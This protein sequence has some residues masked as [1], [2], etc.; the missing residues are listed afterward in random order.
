MSNTQIETFTFQSHSLRI[1]SDEKGAPWFIAKDIF[2][3]LGY[4]NSRDMIN[5]LCRVSG[6]SKRYIPELSNTYQLIDEGNLYRLIIK[7]GKPEA[8]A[9]EAWVCDEVLPSIRKTGSY[10]FP[11]F[12][13]PI[14]E[15]I[16]LADFNWRKEVIYRAFENLEKAQVEMMVIVSGKELLANKYLEK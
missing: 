15:P 4:A 1:I 11:E 16:T 9:F 3:I 6:V 10:G 12:L 7:S 14:T 5:K 13:S 8:E 2:D